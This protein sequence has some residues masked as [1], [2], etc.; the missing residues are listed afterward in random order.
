MDML[1]CLVHLARE[2][3]PDAADVMWPVSSPGPREER[4]QVIFLPGS[5]Q[6]PGR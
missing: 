1:I 4:A 2:L 6:V 3:Q 5:P